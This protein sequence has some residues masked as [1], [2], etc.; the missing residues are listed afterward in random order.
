MNIQRL[1]KASASALL[2]ETYSRFAKQL[3]GR[4]VVLCF[5]SV[6]PSA[7]HSTIHPDA[8]ARIL[9]WLAENVDLMPIDR[10]LS[11][12]RRANAKP[13]V[14]LTFDDGHLDN[15]THALPIAQRYGTN[16]CVYVPVG[17]LERDPR[18]RKRFTAVLRQPEDSENDFES[19][20]W[21]DAEIL[22]E[23]GC[24]I[25][26]HTWDHPMLSHLSDQGI[27]YQLSESKRI[28]EERLGQKQ[29]GIAYPYGK[30]NRQVDDRV[31]KA[32]ERLGYTYGLCVEH[33]AIASSDSVFSI[34]RIIINHSNIDRLRN[35]VFGAEDYHGHISRMMPGFVARWISPA[36]FH[37]PTFALPAAQGPDEPFDHQ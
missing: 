23:H 13:A 30:L 3:P 16:F 9:A 2:T 1:L 24:S 28:I 14:A 22:I 17:L 7:T 35:Q 29:I 26:S 25:G 5:H 10:L 21:K 6:H 19:L 31:I 36:D 18:T 12:D 15:L 11:C 37:E 4:K 27:E 33:R 20:S 32:T 34:P 8:F